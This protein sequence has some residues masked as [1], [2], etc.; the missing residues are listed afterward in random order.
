MFISLRILIV[1]ILLISNVCSKENTYQEFHWT[2]G[3]INNKD[4]DKTTI[5]VPIKIHGVDKKLYA[6]LD[7]GAGS[8]RFYGHILRKH[9]IEVDSLKEPFI[10]FRWYDFDDNS[11]TPDSTDYY[12]WNKNYEVDLKSDD[13]NENIVGTV[14]MKSITDKILILD[15]PNNKYAVLSDTLKIPAL[16]EE[17]VYY[18]D[19]NIDHDMYYVDICLGKDTIT[20]RYDSGASIFTLIIPSDQWKNATGL[21]GDE[22]SI[23]R[24][25][26]P[27]WAS[28]V[29]LLN[30]PSQYDLTFGPIHVKNP[31]VTY[32][33][34]YDKY[35]E[36]MKLIGNALFY[37]DYVVVVDCEREKFGICESKW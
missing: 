19:A 32:M 29:Y 16:L 5:L 30:A 14:G 15:F 6:Q 7:T 34:N 1:S 2:S 24:D 18:L 28:Y 23:E 9:G 10:K 8:S 21:S 37:D 20:V 4:Y 26:V 17:E 25:S 33:E 11:I 22:D 27:S 36:D 12:M 3:V 13:P 31:R 35:S